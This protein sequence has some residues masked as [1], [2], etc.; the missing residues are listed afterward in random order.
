MPKRV[1]APSRR[2]RSAW[3]ASPISTARLVM[4]TWA[5]I[6]D[7]DWSLVASDRQCQQLAAP[8]VAD[9]EALSLARPFGRLRRGLRRA[10]VGRRGARQSRSRP[11]LG[12]H[13]VRRRPDVRA[14]RAVDRGAPQDPAARR[15]AQQPRLPPGGHARAAPVQLPQSRRR[16]SAA[17]WA[18]SAPASRIPTSSITSSRNRWA[19]GRRGRSRIRHS[20]APAIKE[21]VAVVKSGQ[22]ALVNVWTQPR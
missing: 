8:A 11:V 15:D 7:L 10:G 19:G 21:A 6:K 4:E 17:T 2:R 22:P 9:G 14:G 3:D 13:P 12:Q 5:Q 18:R 20:S 16:A 1:S